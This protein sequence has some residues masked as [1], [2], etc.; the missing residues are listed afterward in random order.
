MHDMCSVV[1]RG[2]SLRSR[3]WEF[4]SSQSFQMFKT[5]RR[6]KTS[7]SSTLLTTDSSKFSRVRRVC[8]EYFPARFLRRV[9]SA[10][11][12]L[13]SACFFAWGS[14]GWRRWRRKKKTVRREGEKEGGMKGGD[15]EE[16]GREGE[17]EEMVRREG[18]REKRGERWR[19]WWR[20]RMMTWR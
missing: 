17:K 9:C 3:S 8:W 4:E 6:K 13:L 20:V 12:L 5:I 10:I 11:T 19:R 16:G 1:K 7:G 18:W 2:L 14:L 15:G